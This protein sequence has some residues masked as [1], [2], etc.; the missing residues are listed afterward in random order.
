MQRLRNKAVLLAAC[1]QSLQNQQTT[2]A[3]SLGASSVM[4]CLQI[5]TYLYTHVQNWCKK[6]ARW[7]MLSEMLLPSTL[8]FSF[9]EVDS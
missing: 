4:C 1:D 2:K 8:I 7:P 6:A 9:P 3:I 5:P